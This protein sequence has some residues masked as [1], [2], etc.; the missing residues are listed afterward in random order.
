MGAEHGRS[1]RVA[2]MVE[3]GRGAAIGLLDVGGGQSKGTGVQRRKHAC[4]H[5]RGRC[6]LATSPP[7]LVKPPRVVIVVL[8]PVCMMMMQQLPQC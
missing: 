5:V 4:V 1:V 2:A 3:V 6:C 8:V 7:C